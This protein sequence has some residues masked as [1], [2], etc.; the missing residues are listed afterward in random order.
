MKGS[1]HTCNNAQGAD[2]DLCMFRALSI[3]THIFS[4][5][6]IEEVCHPHEEFNYCL[7]ASLKVSGLFPLHVTSNTGLEEGALQRVFGFKPILPHF[8]LYKFN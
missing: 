7:P 1:V 8:T 5:L 6:E 3:F 4:L 2:L